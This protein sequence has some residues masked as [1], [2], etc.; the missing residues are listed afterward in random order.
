MVSHCI[1]RYPKL[2]EFVLPP[3]SKLGGG[4]RYYRKVQAHA[5]E[6]AQEHALKELGRLHEDLA[7]GLSSLPSQKRAAVAH[8]TF[9]E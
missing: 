1:V 7:A 3:H 8:F 9:S 6:L 2:K 5:L 4:A